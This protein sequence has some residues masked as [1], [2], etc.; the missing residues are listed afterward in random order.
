V[1]RLLSSGWNNSHNC[2]QRNNQYHQQCSFQHT[3]LLF[4]I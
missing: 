4:Y 2:Q 3:M 1:L